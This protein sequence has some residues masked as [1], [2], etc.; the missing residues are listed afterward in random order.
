MI[1]NTMDPLHFIEF[2]YHVKSSITPSWTEYCRLSGETSHDLNN[3]EIEMES[4]CKAYLL[5]QMM[6]SCCAVDLS[7]LAIGTGC[8]NGEVA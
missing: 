2:F 4:A 1:L 7:A 3:D 6:L 5:Q 8:G